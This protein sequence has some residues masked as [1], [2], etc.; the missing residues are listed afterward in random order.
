MELQPQIE[1]A[2]EVF[3]KKFQETF[4]Q[5]QHTGDQHYTQ[6]LLSHHAMAPQLTAVPDSI[7][8]LPL[9]EELFLCNNAPE[10]NPPWIPE[11]RKRNVTV[12]FGS[13]CD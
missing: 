7:A 4:H 5:Q 2:A 3:T 13:N 12:F 6:T 1:A 11:L 8:Q 9:L 10:L